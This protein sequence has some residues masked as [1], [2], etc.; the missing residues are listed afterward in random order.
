MVSFSAIPYDRAF[1]QVGG[2]DEQL[3][4]EDTDR[5]FLDNLPWTATERVVSLS[6]VSARYFVRCILRTRTR[7]EYNYCL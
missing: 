4:L 5:S 6:K 7:H 1:P 2:H 3:V